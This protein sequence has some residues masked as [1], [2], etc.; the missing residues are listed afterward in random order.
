MTRYLLYLFRWQCSTPIL[1]GALY[2][3]SSMNPLYATIIAN[4][5]GGC[6]FFFV[7]RWIFDKKVKART[8]KNR[9]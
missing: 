8:L 6:I 3:M 2:F 4:F 1:W 5:L 9:E 7:D